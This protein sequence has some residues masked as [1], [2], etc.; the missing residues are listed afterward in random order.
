MESL[1]D[2][3]KADCLSLS[4]LQEVVTDILKSQNHLALILWDGYKFHV[5]N[6]TCIFDGLGHEIVED[7][8]YSLVLFKVEEVLG[9]RISS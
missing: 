5:S 6:N 3:D 2:L 9:W 4:S 8:L 1:Q 7:T